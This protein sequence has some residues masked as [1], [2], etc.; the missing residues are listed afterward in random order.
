MMFK[1]SHDKLNRIDVLYS[2]YKKPTFTP[3]VIELILP[4]L[5]KKKASHPLD[6]AL[7]QCITK[8]G[9][10][11]F[12]MLRYYVNQVLDINIDENISKSELF[13][14]VVEAIEKDYII[15]ANS[16]KV[17]E[18]KSQPKPDLDPPKGLI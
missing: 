6:G 9:A 14:K 1:E 13:D 8:D 4:F 16:T 17:E 12:D 15:V 5:F 10:V 2:G 11:P 18:V 7:L 3:D